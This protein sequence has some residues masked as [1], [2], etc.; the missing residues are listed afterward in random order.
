MFVLSTVVF[1]IDRFAAD[2]PKR[3]LFRH[4]S[5]RGRGRPADIVRT[6]G[7]R[8]AWTTAEAIDAMVHGGRPKRR[9]DGAALVERV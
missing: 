8:G 4:R 6:P 7:N 2:Q 3:P 1:A 9:G 5:R